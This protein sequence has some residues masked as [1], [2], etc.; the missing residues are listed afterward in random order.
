MDVSALTGWDSFFIAMA[1]AAA[2]LAGLII[3]AM[4]VTIKEILASKALPSRA[5]ATISSLVLV[6]IASGIV[7]IPRQSMVLMGVLVLVATLFALVLQIVSAVRITQERPKRPVMENT[8]K[9]LFGIL[10]IV[11]FLVGAVFCM[12]GNGA[13]VYWLAAGML[14]AIVYAMVNAWVL[15]VE[16]QR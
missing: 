7:L 12:A 6:L 2:A 13:G 11:P 15:L 1:G 8:Y 10:Q 14:L 9:I 3:V 4:S 5:A 16:V